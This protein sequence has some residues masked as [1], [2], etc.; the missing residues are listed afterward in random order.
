MREPGR[1]ARAIVRHVERRGGL[2]SARALD[3]ELT[4]RAWSAWRKAWA[5]R[6]AWRAGV[7]AF[8]GDWIERTAEPL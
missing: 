3:A 5:L 8:D 2:V 7:L 1:D 4:R 6:A